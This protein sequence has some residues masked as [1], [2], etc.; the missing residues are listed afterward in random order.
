MHAGCG[1]AG[2]HSSLVVLMHELDFSANTMTGLDSDTTLYRL[3]LELMIWG[4]AGN[5]A[6]EVE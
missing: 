3:M 1:V 4:P 2:T 5:L 6:G